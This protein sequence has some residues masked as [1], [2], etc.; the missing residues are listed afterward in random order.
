MNNKVLRI[1]VLGSLILYFFVLIIQG[2][3]IETFNMQTFGK[4]F[5]IFTSLVWLVII[6]D[7]YQKK[8]VDRV[9]LGGGLFGLIG[10]LA[11]LRNISSV[12]YY[13]DNYTQT[14]AFIC[15]FFV[16]L[17]TTFF[18]QAGFIGVISNDKKAI[19][20]AS[21][22]L[23]LLIALIVLWSVYFKFYDLA[24]SVLLP[25]YFIEWAEHRWRRQILGERGDDRKFWKFKW[26]Y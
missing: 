23:L 14:V 19:T 11:F 10:S 20:V 18:T 24:F 22:K 3:K 12:L 1:I 21:F 8:I 16:G 9:Q 25:L 15:I 6:T 7:F 13:Y 5:V 2:Y 26:R 17:I 4:A